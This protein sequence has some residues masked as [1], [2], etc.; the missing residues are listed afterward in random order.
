MI[1]NVAERCSLE[2]VH[3]ICNGSFKIVDMVLY[4]CMVKMYVLVILDR[5]ML[6]HCYLLVCY[7][8]IYWLLRKLY[9]VHG[10]N[11]N[12][13]RRYPIPP[14]NS[15]NFG[16]CQEAGLSRYAVAK[17]VFNMG[18]P[19]AE[20]EAAKNEQ[21]NALFNLNK[22]VVNSQMVISASLLKLLTVTH[23]QITININSYIYLSYLQDKIIIHK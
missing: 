13:P 11:R 7:N 22:Q 17:D 12:G 6:I 19:E 8:K 5:T 23:S 3:I 9:F 1:E 2:V 20:T 16:I 21:I 10:S 14:L 18:I 4:I 15:K